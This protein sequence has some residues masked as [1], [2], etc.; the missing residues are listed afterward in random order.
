MDKQIDSIVS[1]ILTELRKEL[2]NEYGLT[3][4]EIENIFKD[5]DI[6]NRIRKYPDVFMH[7]SKNQRLDCVL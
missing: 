6:E 1:S 3:S 2:V 5:S 7:M 4:L